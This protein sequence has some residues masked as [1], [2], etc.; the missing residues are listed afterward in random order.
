V[1]VYPNPLSGGDILQVVANQQVA[2][3]MLHPNEP[4][5]LELHGWR[6]GLYLLVA[7]SMIGERQALRF[8]VL[9]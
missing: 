8:V 2:G 1:A 4:A 7:E 9:D 3:V 5:G 6:P